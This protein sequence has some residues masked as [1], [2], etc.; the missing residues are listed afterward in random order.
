MTKAPV[1]DRR[2]MF[3]T[4]DEGVVPKK[5][6]TILVRGVSDDVDGYYKVGKAYTSPN[7]GTLVGVRLR[8]K[9][10]KKPDKH[11]GG[12][13]GPQAIRELREKPL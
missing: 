6:D 1:P 8:P 2:R 7:A 3:A 10:L 5:G 12:K 11:R 4:K 9:L 13:P